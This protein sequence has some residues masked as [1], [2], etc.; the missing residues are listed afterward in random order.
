MVRITVQGKREAK[1]CK[2]IR[3][4]LFAKVGQL[5]I[6]VQDDCTTATVLC[7]GVGSEY[8]DWI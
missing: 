5:A 7:F 2:E 1:A 3:E 8:V 4:K 6:E